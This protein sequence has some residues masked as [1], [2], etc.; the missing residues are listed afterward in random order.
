M[1]FCVAV[2]RKKGLGAFVGNASENLDAKARL[3]TSPESWETLTTDA[4]LM[5]MHGLFVPSD[6]GLLHQTCEHR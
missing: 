3:T 2:I 5:Q 1:R 6:H 4:W